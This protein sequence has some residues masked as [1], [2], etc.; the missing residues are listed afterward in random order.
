V[1][2]TISAIRGNGSKFFLSSTNI[3][4]STQY[5]PFYTH[6]I[7]ILW[8]TFCP[9]SSTNPYEITT[10]VVCT[11]FNFVPRYSSVIIQQQFLIPCTHKCTV[12]YV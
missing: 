3:L 1:K 7:R 5:S 11:P 10:L 4:I 2:W 9:L 8:T 12:K 6:I